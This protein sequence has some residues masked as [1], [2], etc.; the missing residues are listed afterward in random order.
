[1]STVNDSSGLRSR[2]CDKSWPKLGVIAY[3]PIQYHTPLY[4]L[5][6]KRGNVDLDVFFLSDKGFTSTL[7]PG[8]GLA[9]AWDIDL[10]SGYRHQFMASVENPGHLAARVRAL[11]CWIPAHDAV[12]VNGYTS[13]WMLLAMAICKALR[14]PYLL[15]G[16]SHPQGSSAGVRRHL[17]RMATRLV[18]SGSAGGLSMG[19]LNEAFYKQNGARSIT[20][21]PNSVDDG[22]F[23]CPPPV[24]RSDLLARWGLA[25][26][27][28]VIL[29]CGKLIPRKRPLDLVAAIKL[30]PGEVTTLF[31]GDGSLAEQVRSLLL[32]GSGVVTGFVN[33]SDLPMYYHAADVLVLPSET[34]AWGLVVNEAMAAGTLP[35]VSDSVGCVPDLVRDVGEVFG[36]G[37]VSSLATALDKALRRIEEVGIRSE[38]RQHAARYSLDRTAAG[39]EEAVHALYD[40]HSATSG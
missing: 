24:S 35:V 19:Q 21:A 13:P 37:D 36:C 6:A 4:Q 38:V 18:V 29:F 3:G 5:L 15:R 28:P 26:S 9:V 33:Q 40:S 22:R 32:P 16:S 23:G 39:F 25:D 27:N 11:A 20:F 14:I 10:L 30:L 31:V 17:R 12:I 2:V 8:F 7:D 1:M 34:E